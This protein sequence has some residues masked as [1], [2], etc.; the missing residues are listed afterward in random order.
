M[1]KASIQGR[2]TTLLAALRSDG[3]V[4][5]DLDKD[6]SSFGC[7]GANRGPID[8]ILSTLTLVLQNRMRKQDDDGLFRATSSS[9]SFGE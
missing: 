7:W 8:K 3:P 9:S 2:I 4:P 5:L 6:S 1:Y